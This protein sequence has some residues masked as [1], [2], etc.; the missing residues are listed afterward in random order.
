MDRQNRI[1]VVI[2]SRQQRLELFC[3]KLL[4]ECLR[5]RKNLLVGRIIILLDRKLNQVN[6]IFQ[7]CLQFLEVLN[8]ALQRIAL[9]CHLLCL[10][11]VIP[12]D[13]IFHLPLHVTQIRFSA[14]DLQYLTK[15][16]DLR[17][18]IHKL[19]FDIIQ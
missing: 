19:V 7:K 12:E 5:I 18:G 14:L 13:F 3:R 4:L 2:L 11:V 8:L 15:L 1:G 10:F 6:R 16:L 9:L 17:S